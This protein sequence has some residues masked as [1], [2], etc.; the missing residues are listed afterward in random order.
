MSLN[1]L[2]KTSVN[3]SQIKKEVFS[4]GDMLI[5]LSVHGGL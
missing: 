3:I 1:F 2:C 5:S 4:K